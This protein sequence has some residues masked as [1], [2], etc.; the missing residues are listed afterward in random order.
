M[1]LYQYCALNLLEYMYV[2]LFADKSDTYLWYI[3][4]YIVWLSE[5]CVHDIMGRTSPSIVPVI[6]N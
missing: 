4:F 3:A 5:S 1:K 6:K 2:S